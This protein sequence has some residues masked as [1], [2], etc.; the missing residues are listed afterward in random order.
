LRDAVNP[1]DADGDFFQSVDLLQN[2]LIN[3][4]DGLM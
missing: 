3:V 1:L 4:T 2:H